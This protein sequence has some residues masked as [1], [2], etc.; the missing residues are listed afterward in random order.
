M[1]VYGNLQVYNT[2]LLTIVTVLHFRSLKLILL[3]TI[4]CMSFFEFLISLSIMPSKIIHAVPKD[5]IF[6]FSL[7]V[8]IYIYVYLCIY[9]HIYWYHIYIF[10][11]HILFIHSSIKGHLCCCHEHRCADLFEIAISFPLDVYPWVGLM[12]HM[13]VLLFQITFPPTVYM[14]F[15]FS[16]YQFSI[17]NNHT[18]Q[19]LSSN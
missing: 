8:Y 19:T 4:Y 17:G 1:C 10:I 18:H 9:V 5:K 14:R 3:L 16:L 13:I 15:S 6:S 2:M 12:D 11:C 7:C